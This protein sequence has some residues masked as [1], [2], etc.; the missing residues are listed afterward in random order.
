MISF[1]DLISDITFYYKTPLYFIENKMYYR[2]RITLYFSQ[3]AKKMA[4]GR[5]VLGGV[6]LVFWDPIRLYKSL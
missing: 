4:S 5:H 1:N 2:E 6:S 3:S